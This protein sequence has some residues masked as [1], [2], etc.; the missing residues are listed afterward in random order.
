MVDANMLLT[1]NQIAAAVY[2]IDDDTVLPRAAKSLRKFRTIA[3]GETE[4]TSFKVNNKDQE[5]NGIIVAIKSGIAAFARAK[6]LV[7]AKGNY[8]ILRR[9]G[10]IMALKLGFSLMETIDCADY[11]GKDWKNDKDLLDETV[12]EDPVPEA[13]ESTIDEGTTGVVTLK[14]FNRYTRKLEEVMEANEALADEIASLQKMKEDVMAAVATM[15]GTKIS[16]AVPT[17]I[18]EAFR[19]DQKPIIDQCKASIDQLLATSNAQP[20][21][22]RFTT[23]GL[24]EDS[25]E[26]LTEKYLAAGI[27]SW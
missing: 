7:K 16:E 5:F 2:Y 1:Y 24:P 25:I 14:R 17:M 20:S 23:Q 3:M 4:K 22:I 18:N 9:R 15:I 10:R 13:D 12:V 11:E 21:Q 27:S 8:A 26:K 19:L 6:A